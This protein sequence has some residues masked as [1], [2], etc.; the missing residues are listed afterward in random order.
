MIPFLVSFENVN[1][2]RWDEIVDL[3]NDPFERVFGLLKFAGKPLPNLQFGLL[4]QHTIA[5]FNKVSEELANIDPAK[6]QQFQSE[7]SLIEKQMKLGMFRLNWLIK[8]SSLQQI[9][10]WN[11]NICFQNQIFRTVP[12]IWNSSI[13]LWRSILDKGLF[14]L[15]IWFIYLF[16]RQYTIICLGA[17][18]MIFE[19]EHNAYFIHR[20]Y[21]V[22]KTISPDKKLKSALHLYHNLVSE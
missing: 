9:I 20:N 10:S 1:Q 22:A 3:T 17:L 16:Y 15:V 11:L 14:C 5:K 19:N 6:L 4:A 18:K 7:V 21:T 12:Q 13:C 8:K 2:E